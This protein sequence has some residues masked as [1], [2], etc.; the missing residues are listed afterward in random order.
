MSTDSQDTKTAIQKNVFYVP[1]GVPFV[2]ALTRAVLSG[3]LPSPDGLQPDTL[4]LPKW[5]ILLPTRRAT[6]ALMQ[7]FIDEGDGTARLLPRIQPLGDVDED[8]LSLSDIP[9]NSAQEPIPDPISGLERQFV[10]Y[11]LIHDWVQAYSDTPLSQL[12][13]SNSVHAFDLARS[14]G[15]LVDSFETNNVDLKIIDNLFDGEFAEH[16]LQILGFLSIVQK[17]LPDRMAAMNKIGASDHRNRLMQAHS[18]FLTEGKATG[19]VIAAGSTGSIPSTAQLLSCIADMP[20][21]AVV[22]PGLDVQLDDE[23]WDCLPENHPQFGMRELLGQMGVSRDDVS[24]LPGVEQDDKNHAQNWLASEIMRPA[25]TTDQWRDAVTDSRDTLIEATTNVT[26]LNADDQRSEAISI[27]L[28]MRHVLE[29]KK[30]A[31]LI[32]PDRQLARNVTA[33]LA[34]WNIE[35]DDSAGEPLLHTPHATFLRLLL[36]A[37]KTRFSPGSLKALL[38]HPFAYFGTGEQDRATVFT[39]LEIALLRSDIPYEGLEGLV[40]LC[41]KYMDGSLDNPYAHPAFKRLDESNWQAIFSLI[42][43]LLDTLQPLAKMFESNSPA[44]LQDY[45]SGHLKIAEAASKHEKHEGI[46][47]QGD[48]GEKLSEMFSKLRAAAHLAPKITAREYIMLLEQQLSEII[49]RPKHVRHGT[50]AIYGLLEARLISADTLIMAGLNETIWP[51]VS[52][53]D[54]WLTRPQLRNAGLP[55]PERRIGLSAHDFS[56][57]FCASQVYLTYS[58]KLGNSPAV[59][60]RWILRLNALLKASGAEHACDCSTEFPWIYWAGQIDMAGKFLPAVRPSPKPAIHLRPKIF[61]VT[62]IEKLLK[63]PYAFFADKVLK[64]K[65]LNSLDQQAGAAERGSLVH[66]ALDNFIKAHPDRLPEDAGQKLLD[67]FETLLEGNISDISLKVFWRPQL[68]RM[69]DWFIEQEIALRLN[70]QSSHTEVTGEYSFSTASE[71]YKLTA[72][73]DRVDILDNNTARIIDYK[74]GALPSF[75]AS[76]NG[77]SPQLLLEALISA[78]GGFNGIEAIPVSELSY[79]KL[80]GGVPAGEIK[81]PRIK[82]GDHLETFISDVEHGMMELLTACQHAEQPYQAKPEPDRVGVEREYDYLSRWREWAHLLGGSDA[83]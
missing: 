75:D 39:N 11:Q 62:G 55:V 71:Q 3:H 81:R 29:V 83:S 9:Y 77:F 61:S 8:E 18:R 44:L 35:I 79:I 46:L 67:E 64:L 34:R 37:A 4:E 49:V 36:E 10:L 23:S 59:A 5:T 58:K 40:A 12:L 13:A 32:T 73:A 76:S 63:N 14:L 68:A 50:L 45:I 25:E 21:G 78:H 1:A 66:D 53:V 24:L 42:E 15:T 48:R 33:E 65:P 20:N 31:A 52:E 22:L 60:S 74:T 17:Q 27:A 19:P 54:A 41:R 82:K 69:A 80:S 30:T 7:A 47:W 28:I 51:Q 56:Q 26:V 6:R 38:A 70:R 43:R 2:N 57:G 72:R 16:R